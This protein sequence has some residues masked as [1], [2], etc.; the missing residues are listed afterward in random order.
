MQY[1][2]VCVLVVL[3]TC[4]DW[5]W[6]TCKTP[7]PEKT[8]KSTSYLEKSL[9]DSRANH[10]A[11]SVSSLR[12]AVPFS[13]S[14]GPCYLKCCWAALASP[15]SFFKMAQPPISKPETTFFNEIPRQFKFAIQLDST[16]LKVC[17]ASDDM[18]WQ[19]GP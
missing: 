8:T 1:K 3:L 2:T 10:E 13:S 6:R 4:D 14:L 19:N 17:P 12:P 9:E 18:I 7:K 16:G 15:A 11:L 5:S